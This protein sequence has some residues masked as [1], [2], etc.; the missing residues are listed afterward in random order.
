MKIKNTL[1]ALSIAGALFASLAVWGAGR[2]SATQTQ[3][4][5]TSFGM[6]GLT[7]GQTIRLNVVHA[8][9]SDRL[10][11]GPCIVRLN[12]V[13]GLGNLLAES[14]ETL[15]PGQATSLDVSGDGIIGRA[16]N[17]A[18]VRAFVRV[19]DDSRGNRLP[20]NPCVS[21]LE[22]FESD[23]GKTVLLHPGTMLGQTLRQ[24]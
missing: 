10:P 6:V 23:T 22:V 21:T 24:D 2:A 19:I 15:T 5:Y 16:S 4:E 11:P 1:L 17:R 7:R 14:T 3:M 12:F 18:E 20:P 9:V 13:D 8:A